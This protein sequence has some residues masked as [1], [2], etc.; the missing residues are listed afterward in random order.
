MWGRMLHA[1]HLCITC[2][3][4]DAYTLNGRYKCFECQE[5][6]REHERVRRI[7]HP[8]IKKSEW[9]KL[10][11]KQN[12]RRENHQCYLCGR[13]LGNDP[14]KA[15]AKCR[16]YRNA[17]TK[18]WKQNHKEGYT[19]HEQRGKFGTCYIC[20]KPSM[21]EKKLCETCYRKACEN[22]VHARAVNKTRGKDRPW[23]MENDLIF[24][25]SVSK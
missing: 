13:S 14:H 21:P 1:A 24:K 11:A 12:R 18:K 6:Q 10:K 20:L 3:K 8:E 17:A 19:P 7:Q 23:A 9:Q 16:A 4:Q 5:K 2:K 22:A 15:C 25:R